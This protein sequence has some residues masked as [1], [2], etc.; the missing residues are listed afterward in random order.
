[1][2]QTA[3]EQAAFLLWMALGM[4]FTLFVLY[5][6]C[7][8][9]QNTG[10]AAEYRQAIEGNNE[11]AAIDAVRGVAKMK[12]HNVPILVEA[13]SSEFPSVRQ[14]SKTELNREV[15]SWERLEKSS[16]RD[17]SAK[18][19]TLVDALRKELVNLK[20]AE[21]SYASDLALRVGTWPGLKDDPNKSQI[22]ED[23]SKIIL[24]GGRP[25]MQNSNTTA[26][27]PTNNSRNDLNGNNQYATNSMNPYDDNRIN[28]GYDSRNSMGGNTIGGNTS[29]FG[30]RTGMGQPNASIGSNSGGSINSS[31]GS[32][33]STT[34]LSQ[35]NTTGFATH[36]SNNPYGTNAT[37]SDQNPSW[38]HSDPYASNPYDDRR[39]VN[40]Q[41]YDA[42]SDIVH[43]SQLP[44]G[45]LPVSTIN[46]TSRS[47]STG[48]SI[49]STSINGVGINGGT[50]ST[51][52]STNS[53]ND[54]TN[55][56]STGNSGP[57][58]PSANS[59]GVSPAKTGAWPSS[60]GT[61]TTPTSNSGAALGGSNNSTSTNAGGNSLAA[62]G[63]SSTTASGGTTNS[64][65]SN[66]GPATNGTASN[67]AFGSTFGNNASANTTPASSPFNNSGAF[68]TS[69]GMTPVKSG[70]TTSSPSTNFSSGSSTGATLL[71]ANSASGSSKA[72]D[73]MQSLQNSTTSILGNAKS[74][75]GQLANSAPTFDPNKMLNDANPATR[76]QLA[77][78]IMNVQGVDAKGYLLA[79]SKDTDPNVRF[80]AAGV[81]ATSTDP[82]LTKRTIELT[83]DP[84]PRIQAIAQR[85]K[86][87]R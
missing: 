49:P 11:Q 4:F 39:D 50:N 55:P 26:G 22:D 30:Q 59:S 86:I 20:P 44:G 35:P 48:Y 72:N 13:M 77:N 53:R 40:G 38:G 17:V 1:M 25:S 79:L 85:V 63:G 27:Y 64:G 3:K 68:G 28:G 15:V 36:S 5:A 42:G 70:G 14:L 74:Q 73:V 32:T 43:R 46:D 37:S 67:P 29:S 24:A 10:L 9:Q 71:P 47:S 57:S 7:P 34:H 76:E 19:L 23:C 62:W 54:A 58:F 56:F 52:T 31:R 33:G 65:Q 6:L 66:T 8:E 2:P 78:T 82:D 81:M 61:M 45:N 41:G 83:S 84:D 51:G 12:D 16:P 75:L 60:S 80:A 69:S 21:R 18:Y 87:Q